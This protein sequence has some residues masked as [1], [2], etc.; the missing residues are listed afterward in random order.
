MSDFKGVSLPTQ[1]WV[2][3]PNDVID[4]VM[5]KIS[6]AS[7]KV[8]LYLFFIKDPISNPRYDIMVPV[9]TDEF[10]KE[11]GLSKSGVIQAVNELIDGGYIQ[12]GKAKDKTDRVV[13]SYRVVYKLNK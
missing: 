7:L 11:T 1:N 10:M 6:G 5:H 9:T 2:S 3:V 13:N 8:L 12:K 4:V